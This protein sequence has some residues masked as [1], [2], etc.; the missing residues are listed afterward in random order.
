LYFSFFIFLLPER[1]Y[2]VNLGCQPGMRPQQV[3]G[4]RKSAVA[5]F[6]HGAS[7][8]GYSVFKERRDVFAISAGEYIM[9]T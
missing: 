2:P 7:V 1:A 9:E 3:A 5:G 6:D 8:F 4:K